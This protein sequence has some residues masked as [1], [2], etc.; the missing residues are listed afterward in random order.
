M[1]VVALDRPFHRAANADRAVACAGGGLGSAPKA[2]GVDV[3]AH[4][5]RGRRRGVDEDAVGGGVDPAAIV[6]LEPEAAGR[7]RT[8]DDPDVVAGDVAGDVAP[9]DPRTHLALEDDPVGRGSVDGVVDDLDVFG[10]A[11]V[12]VD[13]DATDARRQRSLEVEHLV[14]GDLG[15]QRASVDVNPARQGGVGDRRVAVQRAQVVGNGHHLRTRR[16]SCAIDAR[17]E[18]VAA[19]VRVDQ[20]PPGR[21]AAEIRGLDAV[22]AIQVCR[23]YQ[24]REVVR[25]RDAD[26]GGQDDVTVGAKDVDGDAQAVVAQAE[27]G[28]GDAASP[29]GRRVAEDVGAGVAGFFREQPVLGIEQVV[30][31]IPLVDIAHLHA[32]RLKAMDDAVLDLEAL[33]AGIVDSVVA[34][35]VDR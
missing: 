13:D 31:D 1:Q 20:Q 7:V 19:D 34:R 6:L 22:P 4:P 10:A 21:G 9:R 35:G 5:G 28:N 24:G 27:V 25:H 23:V 30:A 3:E 11:I 26:V 18:R 8:S 16:A 17:N 33:V 29:A 14:V 2:V 15:D 12:S 32:A